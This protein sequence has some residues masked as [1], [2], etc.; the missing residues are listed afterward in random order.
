MFM[1]RNIGFV[2]MTSARAGAVLVHAVVVHD[3]D[4]AGFPVVALS[5]VDLV[6]LAVEDVEE[7]FVDVTVRLR[8]AAGR[9]FFEMDVQRLRHPVLG[10]H[11]VL[12]KGLGAGLKPERRALYDTGQ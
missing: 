9:V 7:R 1:N 8:L 6:A 12:R 5:V 11:E 4:V 3:R 10:L 2:L